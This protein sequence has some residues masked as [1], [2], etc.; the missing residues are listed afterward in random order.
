M[1]EGKPLQPPNAVMPAERLQAIEEEQQGPLACRTS[2]LSLSVAIDGTLKVLLAVAL[3][4][5]LAVTFFNVLARWLFSSPWLWANEV[6]ELALATI[7]FIGGAFSYRRGDHA[8]IRTLTNALPLRYRRACDALVEVLV[9]VVAFAAGASS[10]SFFLARWEQVTPVLQIPAGWF[11]LPL[12]PCMV[13]LAVT[14]IERLFAQ[15]RPTVLAVGVAVVVLALVLVLTHEAWRPWIEGDVAAALTLGVFFVTVLVGLPVGFALLL[16]AFVYLHT[17][18]T[19][20]M[21]MLAQTMT[22]G[23]TGFVLL[24]IPF[25]VFAGIIMERGGISLR[26]VRLV[27]A[28]VGHFRGG[29]YQ[30]MVA[31]MYL[32]SGLS[33]SE[34]A[35]VAAVGLVLRDTMRRQGYSMERATAVLA[36]GAAMGVTVPPSLAMLVLVSATTLSAGA[37][38]IAGFIPAAVVAACLMVLVYFQ[39][40][41]HRA[42]RATRGELAQATRGAVLPFLIP[43]ILFG[44]IFLG[45]GTPTEV[46][47]FAAVYGIVLAGFIYREFGGRAFV[48][49]VIDSATVTGM[50]LFILGAASSFAW[51]LTIAKL[52]QRLVGILTVG[53]QSQWVFLIVSILLI[54]V[55][56]MILEG[57]AAVIILAPIL[58]PLASQL[59][60]N[61]L[62]YGIVL[63]IAM[64]TGAFMPPVGVGFYF[65]CAILET[66]VEKSSREMIPYFLVLVLGLVLVALVPWFTLFLPAL[67][68]VA[69]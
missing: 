38:F 15:H 5:Q 60:V 49:S 17:A 11:V 6:S 53:Q 30:V 48:R 14:A 22:N 13:V 56:G 9:L 68:H 10:F 61:Q 52:P 27:Q 25:F 43:A 35:D 66:T 2:R 39:S 57:L 47:S 18:T 23:T 29:L 8:S 34:G 58:L 65:T 21:I 1:E 7:A 33:G 51:V 63:L 62:H 55:A 36:A 31:S 24:A 59:G 45:M 44:G 46:S 64:N 26:L 16:S 37:L 4:A 54:I 28:L 20:P 19:M 42:P 3:T 67:F 69:G 32:V 41:A 12:V 50:I 40:G